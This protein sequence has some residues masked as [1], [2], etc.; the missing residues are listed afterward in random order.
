VVAETAR[1]RRDLAVVDQ[2]AYLV[3]DLAMRIGTGP[4]WFLTGCG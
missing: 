2:D 3:R 1:L 4:I